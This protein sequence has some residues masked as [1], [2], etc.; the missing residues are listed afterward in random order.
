[1]PTEAHAP[2]LRPPPGLK[3]RVSV[4][5]LG[6]GSSVCPGQAVFPRCGRWTWGAACSDPQCTQATWAIIRATWATHCTMA[7]RA[8]TFMT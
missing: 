8:T 2:L 7:P 4:V 5:S 1:M 3:D 6:K